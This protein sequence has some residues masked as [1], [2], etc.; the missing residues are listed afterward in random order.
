MYH[1]ASLT[2]SEDSSRGG[3]GEYSL[4][5]LC[6]RATVRLTQPRGEGGVSP[7]R[8]FCNTATVAYT[9][10]EGGRGG[11]SPQILLQHCNTLSLEGTGGYAFFLHVPPPRAHRRSAPLRVTRIVP[12][13]PGISAWR[14]T[15]IID[16]SACHIALGNPGLPGRPPL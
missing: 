5:G 13:A 3:G 16:G 11:V 1:T 10:T 12:G 4:P 15:L 14:L 9:L 6:N 8:F 2:I 7:P